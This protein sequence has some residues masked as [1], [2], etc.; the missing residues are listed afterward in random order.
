MVEILKALKELIDCLSMLYEILIG[1]GRW[2][3]STISLSN[4][5]GHVDDS[6]FSTSLLKDNDSVKC[7]SKGRWKDCEITTSVRMVSEGSYYDAV[8]TAMMYRVLC[9][10]GSEHRNDDVCKRLL[11]LV[12]MRVYRALIVWGKVGCECKGKEGEDKLLNFIAEHICREP[13]LNKLK[14]KINET[15]KSKIIHILW[16]NIYAAVDSKI[17]ELLNDVLKDIVKREL[18]KATLARLL[19]LVAEELYGI[20]HTSTPANACVGSYVG[21]PYTWKS[22]VKKVEQALWLAS[23]LKNNA[24]ILTNVDASTIFKLLQNRCGSCIAQK[25]GNIPSS[26]QEQEQAVEAVSDALYECVVSD[27]KE[28]I[29]TSKRIQDFLS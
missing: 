19:A 21:C 4:V 9:C 18:D 14:G 2:E 23:M 15:C 1:E 7:R 11:E 6:C 27:L 24:K 5:S 26:V 25:L 22:T 8:Q 3:Q 12:R 20:S 29:K 28:F 17:E 10:K 13:S 16:P